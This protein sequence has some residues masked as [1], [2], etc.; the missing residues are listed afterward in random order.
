M[1]Y[2]KNRVKAFRFAFAGIF[3]AF[4]EESHLKLHGIA[5][6]FVTGLGFLFD[7]SKTEWLFV[8]SA[9]C[10]VIAFEMLNSAV[11]KLC[12]LLVPQQHPVVKYV[13]D[14]S[15]GAVFIVCVFA[16]AVGLMVFVPYFV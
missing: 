7:I 12:D 14:V 10:L 13:K 4:R 3:N 11:E 1:N 9:M 6:L 15:A 8:V 16:V 2:F 5:A